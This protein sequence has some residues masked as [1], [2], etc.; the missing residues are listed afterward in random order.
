MLSASA[1]NGAFWPNR[2]VIT[3]FTNALRL[4]STALGWT[5]A[6]RAASK[7]L[8]T[9]RACPAAP[10]DCDAAAASQPA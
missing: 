1:I 5:T 9:D 8:T 10:I 6:A 2:F 3:K 7:A 4:A